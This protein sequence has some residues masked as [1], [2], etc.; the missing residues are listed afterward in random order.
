MLTCIID[1]LNLTR[2]DEIQFGPIPVQVLPNVQSQ[3]VVFVL[4]G[5]ELY[6]FQMKYDEVK[7]SQVVFEGSLLEVR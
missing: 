2:K 1:S 3:E 7:A 6:V 4:A 5:P